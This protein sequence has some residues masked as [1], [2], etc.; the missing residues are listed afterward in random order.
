MFGK[1]IDKHLFVFYNIENEQN[2]GNILNVLNNRNKVRSIN[3]I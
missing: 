3:F 2:F 1:T